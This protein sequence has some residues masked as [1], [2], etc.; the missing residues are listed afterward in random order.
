MVYL[1]QIRLQIWIFHKLSKQ[2]V[3]EV[4]RIQEKLS[5][6]I[7]FFD[8]VVVIVVVVRWNVC[9]DLVFLPFKTIL[10]NEFLVRKLSL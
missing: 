1:H 4:A 9:V 7:V 5:E 3:R 8:I 10:M 6:T 2:M